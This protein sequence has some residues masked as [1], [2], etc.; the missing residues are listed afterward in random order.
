MTIDDE[1]KEII[2]TIR[3]HQGFRDDPFDLD[4]LLYDE[5]LGLD[6]LCVAEL[7]AMLEKKYGKDPYTSGSLPQT[8]RD[9]VEFYS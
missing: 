1:V 8:V 4:T 7:S 3:K 6:S 2:V 9:I 5:G